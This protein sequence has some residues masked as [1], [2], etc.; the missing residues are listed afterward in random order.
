[1]WVPTGLTFRFATPDSTLVTWKRFPESGSLNGTDALPVIDQDDV[2][3]RG[4][5]H[6]VQFGPTGIVG[7]VIVAHRVGD[8]VAISAGSDTTQTAQFPKQFR[9]H[10]FCLFRCHLVLPRSSRY[11]DQQQSHCA[12]CKKRFTQ[13]IHVY[14]LDDSQSSHQKYNRYPPANHLPS[15][16]KVPLKYTFWSWALL[17]EFYYT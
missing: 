11:R 15:N 12:E 14:L 13:K 5:I 4:Q 17:P 6:Q 3:V 1:M 7:K 9:S 10:S 8:Q 2:F 16:R